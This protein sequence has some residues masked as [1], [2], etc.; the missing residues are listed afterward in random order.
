MGDLWVF[1]Y[2][3]L[4][5]K[6]GFDYAEKR[7]ALLRGAHRA[8]C[9]YSWV[10]RGTQERPGLVFGLDRGGACR[11]MA[12]RVPAA[13]AES[14]IAYLREREQ[15]TMVYL[16]AHRRIAFADGTTATAVT[17][18]VDR[19]HPQYAGL[20]PLDRQLDLV[21]GAVGQSGANPE[22][23]LNTAAHLDELGIHDQRVSWLAGQ[24]KG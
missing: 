20:L 14:T 6:P 19:S 22:Y 3:S 18:V 11:G 8:L 4:M 16:E 12:F 21:R 2:G 13:Q 15:V 9:V 1:G 17:Y 24:L 10:H 7:Q 5:W 23:V